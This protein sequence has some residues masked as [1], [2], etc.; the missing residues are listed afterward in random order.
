MGFPVLEREY[1]EW[2]KVE[3]FERES[4]MTQ[5]EKAHIDI[6][7]HLTACAWAQ[8]KHQINLSDS[9]RIAICEL[10]SATRGGRDEV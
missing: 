7:A 5:E 9:Q 6:D 3:I 1:P 8:T 2:F 10:S 4:A